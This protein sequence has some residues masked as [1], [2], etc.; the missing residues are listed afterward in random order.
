M[1]F[2]TDSPTGRVGLSRGLGRI[3][4][5]A[6]LAACVPRADAQWLNYP[7][8]GIPRTA[9]GKPDL[10]APAPRNTDGKPDLS[11]LWKGGGL[12]E[13]KEIPLRPEARGAVEKFR[14]QLNNK[15]TTLA[16]CLPTFLLQAIPST[17]FK[18]VQTPNLVVLL[19]ENF[20]MPLPR[21][22]FLDGR[23]L[24]DVSNPAWMGY[25]VGHW[26]GDTLV[27]QTVGFND[28]GTLPGG[29]PITE[30][31]RVTERYRRLDFGR[32]KMRITVED[33]QTFTEPWTFDLNSTLQPDTELLEFVCEN[34]ENILQHMI[35]PP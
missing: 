33:P 23:P 32:V 6:L 31:T 11:G 27:V 34:N 5:I 30:S 20:G 2:T 15:N 35:G 4:G 22:V 18:I 29:I 25:S 26:E 16:K 10:S 1:P 9:A 24:P 21:Q 8:P 13:L 19:F 7:T 17:L 28:R 12:P 3:V 14:A